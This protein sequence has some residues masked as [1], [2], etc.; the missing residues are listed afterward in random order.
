MAQLTAHIAGL[1]AQGMAPAPRK[2]TPSTMRSAHVQNAGICH[3]Y[4]CA[5]IM[6]VAPTMRPVAEPNIPTVLVLARPPPPVPALAIFVKQGG[7]QLIDVRDPVHIAIKCAEGHGLPTLESDDACHSSGFSIALKPALLP[8]PLKYTT[9]AVWSTDWAKKYPHHPWALLN[10]PFK[11]EALMAADVVLSAPGVLRILGPEVA[12]RALEFLPNGTIQATPI[13]K[14]LL[15]SEPSLPT[16]DAVHRAVEQGS[17]NVQPPAVVAALLSTTTTGAQALAAIA[18]QQPVAA[19]TN[20]PTEVAKAFGETLGT[21]KDNI[22]IIEVSPFPTA[23]ALRSPK[24]GVL[25]E[26]HPCGG[27]VM[28]FPAR[29]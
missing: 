12:P 7:T 22:S 21:V 20:L 25:P 8:P 19:A 9:P 29:S 18:Q 5:P 23:T 16:G 11:V 15:D 24:I 13:D 3:I 10:E 4:R 26:V 6:D 14:I 2:L 27:L 17:R 1:T 28:D